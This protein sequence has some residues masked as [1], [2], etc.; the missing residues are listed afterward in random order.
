MRNKDRSGSVSD[1]DNNDEVIV[2]MI[3]NEELFN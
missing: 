1:V 2:P 3:N